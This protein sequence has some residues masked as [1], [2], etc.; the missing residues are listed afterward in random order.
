MSHL[1]EE[2]LASVEVVL[3]GAAVNNQSLC[4]AFSGGIDSTVLLHLLS[5]SRDRDRLRAIHVNHGLHSDAGAWAMHCAAHCARLNVPFMCLEVSVDRNHGNGPEAAAREARYA[6][7][8]S[9]LEASELLVTGHQQRDQLETVLMALVRGSGVEGLAA[10]PVLMLRDGIQI[11]RPLL[12]VHPDRIQDYAQVH[13]LNWLE[14]PSNV[15]LAF[16]RNYLRSQVVPLLEQRWPAAAL[17][18]TRSA[19][20]CAEAA[21]ILRDVAMA[22][23]G[24]HLR[25]NCLSVR[26]LRG[27]SENRQ[28]NLL[29]YVARLLGLPVPR[30]A[31]LQ[32]M[33]AAVL[34]PG[35]NLVSSG[36]WPGVVVRRYREFLWFYGSSA[37]PGDLA[38]EVA[39]RSW[40][41]TDGFGLM[42]EHGVLQWVR[43]DSGGIG[44]KYV[45]GDIQVRARTGGERLRPVRGGPTRSLKNLLQEEGVLPWMRRFIPLIYAGEQLLAVG[46]LWLNA[47]CCVPDGEAGMRIVWR[48][49]PVLQ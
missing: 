48:D 22:D 9:Q 26:A 17:A 27:L 21:D 32:A 35:S 11:A 30:A 13:E 34:R 46:D 12:N 5:R 3:A 25:S 19:R 29:R 36:H 33:S 31:Q 38:P 7:L 28:R 24:D 47:D 15:E 20:W 18:A 39:V 43:S 44:P 16:D 1:A 37:D 8:R 41:G 10:M 42:H 40:Q 49:R 45:S 2:L 23:A 4:V 14:D 6:A